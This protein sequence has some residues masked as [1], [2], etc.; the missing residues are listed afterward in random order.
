MER[1]CWE[2]FS[3]KAEKAITLLCLLLE[4]LLVLPPAFFFPE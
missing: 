3:N 2:G 1:S 4:R